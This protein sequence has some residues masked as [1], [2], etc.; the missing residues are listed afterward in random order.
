MDCCENQTNL[1]GGKRKMEIKKNVF[2]W[3]VIGVLFVIALYLLFKTGD[4][5]AVQVSGQAAT[6]I[7][8]P[9]Q[10]AAYGGMVGGC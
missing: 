5:S 8:P 9:A 1:K 2:L 7:A 10:Q 3:I 6:N 4:S